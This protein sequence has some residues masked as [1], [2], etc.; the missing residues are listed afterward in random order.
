MKLFLNTKK[1]VTFWG[2]ILFKWNI[3]WII[4][5]KL[6]F[7][8]TT[9]GIRNLS[10]QGGWLVWIKSR[11]MTIKSRTM[12][13]KSRPMTIKSRPMTIKTSHKMVKPNFYLFWCFRPNKL[14]P[15]ALLSCPNGNQLDNMVTLNLKPVSRDIHLAFI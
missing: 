3:F 14:S 1:G 13:I 15:Q 9:Y 8:L 12:T 7:S 11:P 6:P 5:S 2:K 10:D 4:L